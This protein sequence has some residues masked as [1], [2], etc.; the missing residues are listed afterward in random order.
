MN[1]EKIRKLK[2][3]FCDELLNDTMKFW[4]QY[5]PDREYGGY[6]TTIDR[7]GTAVSSHKSMWIH[8]RFIWLLSRLYA[9]LEK[10]QEWLDLAQSG[11][12]FISRNA[13]DPRG[14]MYF[15]LARDGRPVRMRRYL[16][17]EV[18]AVMA[19]AE[20]YRATQDQ[21]Y[22]R[23]ARELAE[24]IE[25]HLENPTP[26]DQKYVT[27]T[28]NTRGHSMAMIRI[29]MYQVL[30]EADPQET[31]DLLIDRQIKDVMKYFVKPEEK[32]LLETVGI[33]GEILRDIPEG[34]C[35]NP[36]HAVETAWF[37]M[38][39]GKR[40]NDQT[41]VDQALPILDWS[42]E[43]GWDTEYGGLYSFVDLDGYTPVQIE[44]DMK[45]WWPHNESLYGALL[46]HS[47]T[48]E[49]RY[50]EWFDRILS[51][52]EAHFPDR[53][54]GEWYG[55]LRRDGSVAVDLKASGWKGPF[56]LPR[57]Q[58]YCYELLKEMEQR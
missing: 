52:S 6:H 40:R 31:Y 56:H 5:A 15:T 17:S 14:R 36:G 41:L 18:F 19:Y 11:I 54:Y 8:G 38:S 9:T 53:E 29:N 10:R 49:K 32:A 13:F 28:Y 44:H 21:Q 47:L 33:N 42:F 26:A 37:I 24:L 22:L 1:K 30:R 48:G 46:A 16:F 55:Y 2:T 27:G 57:Q 12:D 43:R 39:E 34:R 20:F 58:L 4:T 51:W 25:Y 7:Q 35:I 50:E 23:K 3:K 45:Y